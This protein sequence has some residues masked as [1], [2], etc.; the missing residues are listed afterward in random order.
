MAIFT[1]N[2]APKS[3]ASSMLSKFGDDMARMQYYRQQD[4]Q[5]QEAKAERAAEYRGESMAVINSLQNFGGLYDVAQGM[6]NTYLEYENAGDTE[7]AAMV[8]KQLDMTLKAM[9]GYTSSF[10]QQRNQLSDDK[11]LSGFENTHQ[12]LQSIADEYQNRGYKYIGFQDGSH[13]VEDENGQQMTVEQIPGLSDGTT[14][15]ND[16]RVMVKEDLPAG[17]LDVYQYTSQRAN[18][19]LTTDIVDEYG[20]ITNDKALYEKVSADFDEKTAINEGQ[21]LNMIYLDQREKGNM[22]RYDADKVAQLAQDSKYVNGL[23]QQFVTD[24]VDQIKASIDVKD[25]PAQQSAKEKSRFVQELEVQ[26]GEIT[27]AK[28]PIRFDIQVPI[29]GSDEMKGKS[30]YIL[31]IKKN[32]KGLPVIQNSVITAEASAAGGAPSSTKIENIT[33]TRGSQEWRGLSD[34]LGGEEYLIQALKRMGVDI[35][36]YTM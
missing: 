7:N 13:I 17:Y 24:A 9:S 18:S 6:Y 21:I 10:I 31:G 20:R 34:Y 14:F 29:E 26:D 28:S 5:R 22:S 25:T 36:K 3:A 19:M 1:E 2:I 33:L 12:D 16:D 23:K 8:R 35:D 30:M 32:D 15:L 11:V 4:Q 27:T